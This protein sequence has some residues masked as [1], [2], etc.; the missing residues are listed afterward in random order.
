ACLGANPKPREVI[1]PS[2]TFIASVSAILWCNLEPV[3]VD[4][5]P[6]HWHVDPSQLAAALDSRS[7]RVAAVLACSTFGAAPPVAVRDAWQV[8]CQDAGVP[9]IVDSA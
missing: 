8:A 9:L 2:F 6:E 5:A 4:V 1:V 3:F 7:S